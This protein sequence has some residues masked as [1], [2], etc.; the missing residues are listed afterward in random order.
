MIPPQRS[1]CLS[2]AAGPDLPG[3]TGADKDQPMFSVPSMRRRKAGRS[4]IQAMR[5]GIL[6]QLAVI[7]IAACLLLM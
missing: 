5:A 4:E 2:L 1:P 3:G 6:G 7:I